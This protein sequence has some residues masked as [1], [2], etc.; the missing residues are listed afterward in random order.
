[1]PVIPAAGYPLKMARSSARAIL[2]RAARTGAQRNAARPGAHR[3]PGAVL[4]AAGYRVDLGPAEGKR[5]PQ[6]DQAQRIALPGQDA[7]GQ[8]IGC[9]NPSG[10]DRAESLA[11]RAVH[12]HDPASGQEAPR[13]AGCLVLDLRPRPVRDRSKLAM[14]VVH[15]CAF[16]RRL[17]MLSE[18]LAP[19]PAWAVLAPEAVPSTTV[20]SAAS[21]S[22]AGGPARSARPSSTACDGTKNS[23]PVTAVL[24]SRIRS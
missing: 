6:L 9:L 20:P 8:R 23:D 13:R 5:R 11:R 19:A 3:T 22:E 24:K 2:R 7:L 16:P 18:P 15:I 17:P 14:Q 1:M 10:A 21:S 12:V 4:R